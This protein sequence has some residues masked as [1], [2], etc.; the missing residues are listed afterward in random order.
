[1]GGAAPSRAT[2]NLSS[3][4]GLR[5]S[6]APYKT[7]GTFTFEALP[8]STYTLSVESPAGTARVEDLELAAGEAKTDVVVTLSPRAT[9]RGRLIDLDTREPVPGLIAAVNQASG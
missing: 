6:F 2:I 9:V 3:A 1:E 5:R 8:P 7:G 4:E